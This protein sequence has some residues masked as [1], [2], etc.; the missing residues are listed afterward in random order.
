MRTSELIL[1]VISA[2]R[3]QIEGKTTIQKLTYF[4]NLQVPVTDT[5][6][7]RP[8]FYGP[9]SAQADFQL[10]KLVLLGFLDQF[11]RTTINDRIIY[12]FRLTNQGERIVKSLKKKYSRE[13]ERIGS[14]VSI[15]KKS[16]GL[17]PST[18]SYA[19]K[20]HH[21][22]SKLNRPITDSEVMREGS[23]IGWKIDSEGVKKGS[24]LLVALKLAK[25]TEA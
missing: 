16:A 11:T 4:S 20:V 18:L 5:I 14:I 24:V 7:F 21:I 8:H 23:R 10:D 1:A 22:L 2:N 19:A 17:N 3:G 6:V 15:C 25:R 13:F 9:Y 12:N